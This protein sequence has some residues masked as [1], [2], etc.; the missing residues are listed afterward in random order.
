MSCDFY[1]SMGGTM[2]QDIKVFL[3]LSDEAQAFLE[4]HHINLYEELQDAEPALRLRV[5]Q[6]THRP[7]A[8]SA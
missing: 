4:Q 1:V 8:P 5:H 3:D 2:A 6:D 7:L